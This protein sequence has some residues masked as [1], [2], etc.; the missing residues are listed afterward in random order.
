[1]ADLSERL[2]RLVIKV[3]KDCNRSETNQ[4]AKGIDPTVRAVALFIRIRRIEK[5]CPIPIAQLCVAESGQPMNI[6]STERFYIGCQ[7]PT[8]LR[9]LY[10]IALLK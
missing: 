7:R 5:T 10:H 6:L 9:C 4:I 1:M 8:P 2:Q 3:P